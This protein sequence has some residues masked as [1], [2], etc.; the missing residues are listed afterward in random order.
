MNGQE[1]LLDLRIGAWQ[2]EH[3]KQV[4]REFLSET[5][6]TSALS[7]HLCIV[8]GELIFI[9]DGGKARIRVAWG[10]QDEHQARGW[11]S[12]YLVSE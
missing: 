7:R 12:K 8:F 10:P 4:A 2:G 5:P 6:P 1:T 11:K 3:R 9:G